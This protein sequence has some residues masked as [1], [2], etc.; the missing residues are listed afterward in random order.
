MFQD[1]D[2]DAKKATAKDGSVGGGAKKENP[3]S[4]FSF[5][6]DGS[7]SRS[8]VV[9]DAALPIPIPVPSKTTTSLN[10]SAGSSSSK[11]SSFSTP[12]LPPLPTN[13]SMGIPSSFATNDE[14]SLKAMRQRVALK[15]REMEKTE[16]L[17][18][19]ME[20]EIL[21]IIQSRE[22]RAKAEV[23]KLEKELAQLRSSCESEE[24]LI[25]TLKLKKERLSK[26]EADEAKQLEHFVEEVESNLER[27]AT[28]A[29]KA[30]RRVTEL[31]T[32][33]I[34]EQNRLNALR[35]SYRGSSKQLVV[36]YKNWRLPE[37]EASGNEDDSMLERAMN[38]VSDEASSLGESIE[39]ITKRTEEHL[40]LLA[41]DLQEL[42]ELSFYARSFG[43]VLGAAPKRIMAQTTASSP[44]SSSPAR[45][46]TTP[47]SSSPSSSSSS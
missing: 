37:D 36:D 13:P 33:L 47:K 28:R 34:E 42:Q 26:Q 4:F 17:I 19:G 25:A 40:S 20:S 10:S 38:R 15:K 29:K 18:K 27:M 41:R 8:T 2:D 9:S 16:N 31:Q 32:F 5:S 21:G 7:S 39:Q 11:S 1:E 30:N 12:P 22:Q 14:A 43:T 3:F 46:R 24:A 44:S 6:S 35:E 45:T 23:E